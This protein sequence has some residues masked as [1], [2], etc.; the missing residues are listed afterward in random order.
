MNIERVEQARRYSHVGMSSGNNFVYAMQ[1]ELAFETL[2]E[3]NNPVDLIALPM[4]FSLRHYLELILKYNIDYFSEFSGSSSM[5]ENKKHK[6]EPLANAFHEHWT[7]V[8]TKF[9][10]S[11]N[12][13]QYF[14]DLQDIV[15]SIKM[16]DEYA[17][18]FRYSNDINGNKH[19]DRLQTI[20]IHA[21]KKQVD[22]V[23]PLLNHTID[24]FDDRTGLMHGVEK[25]ELLSKV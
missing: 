8:K 9:D 12:D 3:S 18:S 7:L 16:M 4:L 5:A 2:Y 11:V 24:L 14:K 19:F 15:T 1:Y 6:I 17:M 10:I 20:D 21:L 25:S 23:K 22:S 13:R